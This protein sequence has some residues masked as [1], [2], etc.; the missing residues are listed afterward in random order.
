MFF[1]MPDQISIRV[2]DD[3]RRPV[4]R[5]REL[6]VTKK[7]AGEKGGA[8]GGHQ[9]IRCPQC[10]WTPGAGDRWG[11]ECGH[12]WNTFDTRG[13]CPQCGKQWTVTQCLSCQVFSPHEAW[14]EDAPRGGE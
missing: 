10:G 13:L 12:V 14:Y 5:A 11:C 9:K 8:K 4:S 2:R 7:A 6:R 3:P 1:S